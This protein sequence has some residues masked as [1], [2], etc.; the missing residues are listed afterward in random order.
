MNPKIKHK[1][2]PVSQLLQ[3]MNHRITLEDG[4][5]INKSTFKLSSWIMIY[6]II[7][8]FLVI[9]VL[10]QGV[11]LVSK[12]KDCIINIYITE[13]PLN[14]P[15]RN[16]F[17]GKEMRVRGRQFYRESVNRTDTPSLLGTR[18]YVPTQQ[19]VNLSNSWPRGG[20]LPDTAWSKMVSDAPKQKSLEGFP[21]HYH[22]PANHVIFH[23]TILCRVFRKFPKPR[24]N[25]SQDH[26][27]MRN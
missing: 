18:Q 21:F 13:R 17:L 1:Q 19:G 20:C 4:R 3:M 8:H 15:L 14:T 7:N 6:W 10:N 24:N 11:K 25:F 5:E 2:K 26:T 22:C 27:I 12:S 9:Q 16:I 23:K